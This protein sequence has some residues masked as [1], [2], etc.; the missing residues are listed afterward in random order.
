VITSKPRHDQPIAAVSVPDGFATRQF[1]RWIDDV[2]DALNAIGNGNGY[3]Q[4]G[5]LYVSGNT[6][7]T[8]IALTQ[9]YYPIAT[10]SQSVTG[11]D[12]FNRGFESDGNGRLTLTEGPAGWFRVMLSACILITSAEKQYRFRIGRNGVALPESCS[13][14]TVSGTPVAGRRESGATHTYVWLEP[15]DYVQGFIGNWT[16]ATDITVVNEQLSAIRQP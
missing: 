7:P 14:G 9:T 15:G 12:T 3:G 5:F 2:T 1:Q 4:R 11:G 6:T 10:P 13:H 8:A 16:N